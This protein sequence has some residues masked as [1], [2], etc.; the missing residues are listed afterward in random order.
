LHRDTILGFSSLLVLVQGTC[1]R[2]LIVGK[3]G[4]GGQEMA[5]IADNQSTFEN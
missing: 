1:F 5:A 4:K 3:A 2:L